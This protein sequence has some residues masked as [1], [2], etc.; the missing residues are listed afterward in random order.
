MLWRVVGYVELAGC[1]PVES[2]R[3]GPMLHITVRHVALSLPSLHR[4]CSRRNRPAGEIVGGQAVAAATALPELPGS[5]LS[6]GS[7]VMRSHR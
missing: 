2:T 3:A 4:L 7:T 1:E 6:A 5:P